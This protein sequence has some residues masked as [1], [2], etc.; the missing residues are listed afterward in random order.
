MWAPVEHPGWHPFLAVA[1]LLGALALAQGALL[2]ARRS[3]L[4]AA[5]SDPLVARRLRWIGAVLLLAGVGLLCARWTHRMASSDGRA[6]LDL[7]D[8]PFIMGSEP[9][10]RWSHYLAYRLVTLTGLDAWLAGGAR[11]LALRLSSVAAGMFTLGALLALAPAALPRTA[12]WSAVLF[13]FLT[14]T[15]VLWAGF[16]ETTPWCYAFTGA[17]L[18]AGLRYLRLELRR[19]PWAEG[20]LLML[21]VWSHGVA[22]FAT[23]AHA[24][25][26]LQ[27]FFAAPASAR[28]Q[29]AR[30]AQLLLV[31]LLPFLALGLTMLAAY[32]FGTGLP[33]SPWF[34]NAL[35]G[36]DRERWVAFSAA[37]HGWR[38]PFRFGEP[39]YL[40]A[41]ANLL[42][43]ACPL[44]LALPLAI[45]RTLAGRGRP[46]L[47]LLGAFCGLFGFALFYN[48]DLGMRQDMDLMGMY[49]LPAGLIVALWW[50]ARFSPGQQRL[51]A[52]WIA[53]ATAGFLLAPAL[54]FP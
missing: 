15:A 4:P 10:G 53:T 28:R 52:V 18:L 48:P 14:P 27:W 2:A 43:F 45:S 40:A 12:R 8:N 36:S 19:P 31:A 9:L 25:L 11:L 17:Y 50:D 54:R 32:Q 47:F 29:P 34:G 24:V 7:A 46:L 21:A 37:Q 3:G 35:G 23:G 6:W 41:Q 1:L 30:L 20:L 44:L 33:R 5:L 38:R 42:L 13:L 51:S 22:C 26:C 39:E 49:A 16:L